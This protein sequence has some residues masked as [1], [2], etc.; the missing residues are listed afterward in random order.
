MRRSSGGPGAHRERAT[1]DEAPLALVADCVLVV[2]LPALMSG[3]AYF[4][5]ERRD[6]YLLRR[7]YASLLGNTLRHSMRSIGAARVSAAARHTA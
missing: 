7:Q 1:L 3:M 5:T 4:R 6:G 2:R